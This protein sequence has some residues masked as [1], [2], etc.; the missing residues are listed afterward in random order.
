M[1]GKKELYSTLASN[2]LYSKGF[3]EFNQQ[4]SSTEKIDKLYYLSARKGVYTKGKDDFYQDY[5][6][7][8]L[9]ATRQKEPDYIDPFDQKVRAK[10]DLMLANRTG[11]TTGEKAPEPQIAYAD[12][13]YRKSFYSEDEQAPFSAEEL[14]AL[15]RI[16]EEQAE[17]TPSTEEQYK[18]MIKPYFTKEGVNQEG[19]AKVDEIFNNATMKVAGLNPS[20]EE[21]MAKRQE[22]K[23]SFDQRRKDMI[24][25]EHKVE[26]IDFV[27]GIEDNP[28]ALETFQKEYVETGKLTGEEYEL[29]LGQARK[30]KDTERR[31]K[32]L[33][34]GEFEATSLEGFNAYSEQIRKEVDLQIGKYEKDLIIETAADFNAD[35]K[36][37]VG[38]IT[39]AMEQEVQRFADDLVRQHKAD[40]ENTP[41]QYR[42]ALMEQYAMEV[43]EFRKKIAPQFKEEADNLVYG[44]RKKHERTYNDRVTKKFD[45][46]YGPLLF[47]QSELDRHYDVISNIPGFGDGTYSEKKAILQNYWKSN[48]GKILSGEKKQEMDRKWNELVSEPGGAELPDQLWDAAEDEFFY[49]MLKNMLHTPGGDVSVYAIKQWAEDT[50]VIIADKRKETEEAIV[51]RGE[52]MAQLQQQGVG[53][54]SEGQMTQDM[55]ER[56]G[57]QDLAQAE[58]LIED[59]LS[60][61]ESSEGHWEDFKAGVSKEFT[62]YLPLVAGMKSLNNTVN[63][64]QASSKLAKG[65]DL[66]ESERLLVESYA[67]LNQLKDAVPATT[68]YTVGD[69]V[70]HGPAF[71]G[72][73]LLTSGG[74]ILG[75]K[76]VQEALMTGLERHM[77]VAVRR[78]LQAQAV[79]TG[80]KE[81]LEQSASKGVSSVVAKAIQ[82]KMVPTS[83]SAALQA[84]AKIA[85]KIVVG[86]SYAFGAL[87]QTTANPQQYL[88]AITQRMTPQVGLM[89]SGQ[90]EGLVAAI[91]SQG[92]TFT[93][94]MIKGFGTTYAE[95]LTEQMGPA[96]IKPFSGAKKQ[97]MRRVTGDAEWFKRSVVG[98]WMRSQGFSTVN[99]ATKYAMGKRLGWHGVME[100]Y[101]E[102]F[103]NARLSSMITGDRDVFDIDWKGEEMPTAIAMAVMGVPMRGVQSFMKSGNRGKG[104]VIEYTARR[105]EED[106]TGKFVIDEELG[107]KIESLSE[108]SKKDAVDRQE[109][110]NEIYSREMLPEEKAAIDKLV[111]D[112]FPDADI[113]DTAGSNKSIANDTKQT[114]ITEEMATRIGELNAVIGDKKAAPEEVKKAKEELAEIEANTQG[115]KPVKQGEPY[116][117]EA[118]TVSEEEG[119][120]AMVKI[121]NPF[122]DPQEEAGVVSGVR[123]SELASEE[124]VTERIEGL[125]Q[126]LEENKDTYTED[127]VTQ[128]NQAISFLE[129]YLPDQP[130][131]RTDI[132]QAPAEE[133]PAS[134]EEY[135]E[136]VVSSVSREVER[137]EAGGEE[138]GDFLNAEMQSRDLSTEGT[139]KD[140]IGRLALSGALS[141]EEAKAMEERYAQASEMSETEAEVQREKVKASLEGKRESIDKKIRGE[142]TPAA[143]NFDKDSKVLYAKILP[144][145]AAGGMISKM[146]YAT[147]GRI[148]DGTENAIAKLLQRGVTN[149]NFFVRQASNAVRNFMGGALYTGNDLNAKLRYRGGLETAQLEASRLT[150]N[151]WK[152]L[153]GDVDSAKRVHSVMDPEIYHENERVTYDELA[154]NE[155]AAYDLLRE[156][157]D[158]IHDVN[159]ANGFIGLE[160]YDKFKGNYIGRMYD[161]Y[162]LPKEIEEEFKRAGHT[163]KLDL[164]PYKER[165]RIIREY[166][167][168]FENGDIT[169]EELNEKIEGL[170]QWAKDHKISDP[171]YLTAKRLAQTVQN[172]AIQEY[173]NYVAQNPQLVKDV[174]AADVDPKGFKKVGSSKAFGNLRGKYVANHIY[175]DLSGFFFA[176]KMFNAFYDAFKWYDKTT[177]RQFLKKS[178]TVYNPQVQLGN[179]MSNFTFS[180]A[181]GIPVTTI[182]KN[183]PSARKELKGY[184]DVYMHLLKHGLLQSDVLSG[185]LTPVKGASAQKKAEV[186]ASGSTMTKLLHG[187]NP[188]RADQWASKKYQNTDNVMKIAGYLS[189][190]DMGHSDAEARKLVY[191]SYQNYATVG[192]IWDVASKT[193]LIGPPFVKFQGDLLRIAK[194]AATA[195]P[196]TTAALLIGMK[197]T[198]DMLSEWSGE[199]PEI[200][201][202]REGRNFIPR[203]PIGKISGWEEGIPLVWKVKGTEINVARFV[204]PFYIYDK[205][206]W[207]DRLD[208]LN[209]IMPF[210]LERRGTPTEGVETV[211]A[212]FADP[213]L[214][215]LISLSWD[216]DFRGKSILDPDGTRYKGTFPSKDERIINALTYLGRSWVPLF[217][218]AHDMKL[219]YYGHEDYYGRDKSFAQAFGNNIVKMREFGEE[220]ANETIVKEFE[221]LF[222]QMESKTKAAKKVIKHTED[223]AV[224]AMTLFEGPESTMTEKQRDYRIEQ[225]IEKAKGRFVELSEEQVEVLKEIEERAIYYGIIKGP[226]DGQESKK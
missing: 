44:I 56:M 41:E 34:S 142:R 201:K 114:A 33:K 50:K 109:T 218:N 206:N 192:K 140:K 169:R 215:P 40:I 136:H 17:N 211:G 129:S 85:E 55:S 51:A 76:A 62:H 170:R 200:K 3:D 12:D 185:D 70:S 126:L 59:I 89:Y 93:E 46:L 213:V 43:E 103:A 187:L 67:G 81:V 58:E 68:G 180:F 49:G 184:G 156:I 15:P 137:L 179:F 214:G 63:I 181:A 123:E 209:K 132:A 83:M 90:G 166:Q 101:L 87:A 173:M 27:K 212:A 26:T 104:Y 193:P 77:S 197:L 198:A 172:V 79:K 186:K 61:P 2:G 57:V 139:V 205:G 1:P 37:H 111:K 105:G 160:T 88:N 21:E 141:V 32:L 7:D 210:D 29:I 220:Q 134:E 143:R 183:L 202:I 225:A 9:A 8:H 117:T 6:A 157:N 25:D 175:E 127:Q 45:E 135:K 182:V 80:G 168:S 189:F 110:V 161:I 120:V 39:Q 69:I 96:L 164:D 203:I 19:I 84:Q 178:F 78:E 223:E 115:E 24:L 48:R 95:F 152:L 154:D 66:N 144:V 147:L 71:I 64:Y 53:T 195:R 118:H 31:Y 162:E 72:E 94:A 99:Q 204:S 113:P 52:D 145:A 16:T 199:D 224:E 208:K 86:A 13:Y 28:A 171:I 119:E 74:F 176:N 91:Q 191:D 151:A 42:P 4:F 38:S 23:D 216:R 14:A 106:V 125:N 116:Q 207:R 124:V 226:V 159:F 102:E 167:E 107:E 36:E 108:S 100:E 98:G 131:A 65:E 194:N 97:I 22:I 190:R 146:Q 153:Q 138:N 150:D 35:I 148:K 82:T 222:A 54:M 73:F 30:E 219:A 130:A 122:I 133:I 5:F 158:Y 47:K 92:E 112:K 10:V 188:K 196:L 128:V 20:Q 155:K 18:D 60:R 121:G 165:D 217:S 163:H 177:Y 174:D 149:Q 75:R 11:G 221:Y